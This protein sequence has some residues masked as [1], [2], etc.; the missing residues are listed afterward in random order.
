MKTE[1]FLILIVVFTTFRKTVQ[2]C[3]RIRRKTNEA[4]AVGF[5]K[6]VHK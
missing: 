6:M 4:K 1:K 2:D 5:Q 3:I